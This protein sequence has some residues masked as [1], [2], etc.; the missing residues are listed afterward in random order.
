MAGFA[1]GVGGGGG[2]DVSVMIFPTGEQRSCSRVS[3]GKSRHWDM[4]WCTG[5]GL[6]EAG[7]TLQIE[8]QLLQ[9]RGTGHVRIW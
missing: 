7:K 8:M 3:P 1:V 5:A 2:T 9:V 4:L 6:S